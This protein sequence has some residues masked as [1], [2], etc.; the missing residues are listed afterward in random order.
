MNIQVS[1]SIKIKIEDK[2]FTLSRED[3]YAL[4][5]ALKNS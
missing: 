1:S 5:N 3:A 4:F 2:V